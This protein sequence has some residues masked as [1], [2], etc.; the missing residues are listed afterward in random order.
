MSPLGNTSHDRL[1]ICYIGFDGHADLWDDCFLLLNM[2]W[3][4]RLSPTV[5]VNNTMEVDYPGVRTYHAG[6]EAEWSSRVRV[7][8]QQADADYVYLLLDDYY[9]GAPIGTHRVDCLMDFIEDHELRYYQVTS[10][11]DHRRRK[12]LSKPSYAGVAGLTQVWAD[13]RYGISL[14]PAIWRKDYL[15]ELLGEG[16]YDPWSFEL[17]RAAESAS[18]GHEE[19]DG[20]VRD[21]R[22]LLNVKNAVLAG[23]YVP[24]TVRY[25]RSQGI[26]LHGNRKVMPI[27][28]RIWYFGLQRRTLLPKRI[29][30]RARPIAMRLGAKHVSAWRRGLSSTRP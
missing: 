13:E 5:F 12:D 26:Q 29:Y 11:N 19:L 17:D 1:A 20:C 21:T 2:N 23:S 30:N 14:Q 27:S 9:F 10:F 24:S 4:D 22:N 7:A 3:P 6:Q 18:R 16:N 15:T 8:L 28:Q 25:F